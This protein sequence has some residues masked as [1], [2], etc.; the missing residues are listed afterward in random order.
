MH[1]SSSK[2]L[3]S[4]CFLFLIPASVLSQT[5][6]T[7]A[8]DYEVGLLTWPLRYLPFQAFQHHDVLVRHKTDE[9]RRGLFPNSGPAAVAGWYLWKACTNGPAI[10][11]NLG[12]VDGH[13]ASEDPRGAEQMNWVDQT[14]YETVKTRI[15]N[16]ASNRFHLALYNCQDWAAEQLAP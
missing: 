11:D 8:G 6:G 13:V 1:L 12:W 16:P 2:C 10:C 7:P 3:V 14:R 4:L 9:T 5:G 15:E